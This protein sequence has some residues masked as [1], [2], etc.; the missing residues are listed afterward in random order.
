[1]RALQV[2]A[3]IALQLTEAAAEATADLL[4]VGGFGLGSLRE[5]V[6]GG[7]TRDLLDGAKLPVFLV[8]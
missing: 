7:V 4:V 8:H 3:P 1:M 5:H 2:K 6:L